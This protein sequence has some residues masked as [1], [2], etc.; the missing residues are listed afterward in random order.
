MRLGAKPTR[1][2][3]IGVRV[4]AFGRARDHVCGATGGFETYDGGTSNI[5]Y[6]AP[7]GSHLQKGTSAGQPTARGTLLW[8][9]G[10]SAMVASALRSGNRMVT[11]CTPRRRTTNPDTQN[12]I[13]VCRSTS[14]HDRENRD[15]FQRFHA[16]APKP[17]FCLPP[18]LLA[19]R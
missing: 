11:T 5:C 9:T 13:S 16:P 15:D 4:L 10:L 3:I 18:P 19:A 14:A 1:V 8:E 7:H 17:C 12:H 2:Y 6:T